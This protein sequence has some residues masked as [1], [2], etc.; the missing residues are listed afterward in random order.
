MPPLALTPSTSSPKV[1]SSL[2]NRLVEA[3]GEKKLTPAE[4]TPHTSSG[5]SVNWKL[6]PSEVTVALLSP[7]RLPH[8]LPITKGSMT[9]PDHTSRL[10]PTLKP[11][12]PLTLVSSSNLTELPAKE[13]SSI[14][15]HTTAIV[16]SGSMKGPRRKPPKR[17]PV[18]AL[19]PQ[20]VASSVSGK[21]GAAPGLNSRKSTLTRVSTVIPAKAGIQ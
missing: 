10:V 7:E 18:S 8:T 14:S 17:Y 12:R 13:K 11:S 6:V 20:A 9:M 16:A 4:A 3:P 5:S 1:T 15:L 2:A 19:K 21:P